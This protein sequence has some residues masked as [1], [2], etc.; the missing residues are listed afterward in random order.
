MGANSPPDQRLWLMK[1]PTTV[2]DLSTYGMWVSKDVSS[3]SLT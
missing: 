2:F 1:I 3:Q